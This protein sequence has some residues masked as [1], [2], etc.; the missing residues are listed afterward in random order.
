[1]HKTILISGANKGLGYSLSEYFFRA[2]YR[3]FAG[4]RKLDVLAASYPGI[5]TCLKLVVTRMEQVLEA[6]Q[7]VAELP[8][9]L[10]ILVNNAGIHLDSKLTPLEEI[11]LEDSGWSE[12]INVNSFGP[13][14]L[15]QQMLPLLVKGAR[16]LIINISSEAG[17][18]TEA[19]RDREF[20]YYMSKVALNMQTRLLYNYLQPRGFCVLVVHPGWML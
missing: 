9:G 17:S 2:G 5:L 19:W 20:F 11:D 10:D 1:M 6:R 18:I 8:P 4:A 16:K 12:M 14:R 7:Q 3:V 13:L 15:T